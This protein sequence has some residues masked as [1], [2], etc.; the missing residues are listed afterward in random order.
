V[1]SES[2]PADANVAEVSESKTEK[3][4]PAR[5]RKAKAEPKKVDLTDSGLQLVETKADATKVI[6][7]AEVEKRTARKPAS[8][9]KEQKAETSNEPLVMVETQNK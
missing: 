3:K 7:P 8:W 9:Q 5:P 6:A 2:Q 1:A 4:R